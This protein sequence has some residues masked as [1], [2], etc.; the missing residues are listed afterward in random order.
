[1]PI[2]KN[3]KIM[4]CHIIVMHYKECR[5]W[6]NAVMKI[7]FFLQFLTLSADP[8]LFQYQLLT[9]QL[10]FLRRFKIMPIFPVFYKI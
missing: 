8:Y 10:I 6:G 7:I 5:F 9:T 4:H 2:Q 3:W 1:M